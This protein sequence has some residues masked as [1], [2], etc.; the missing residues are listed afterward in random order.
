MYIELRIHQ[1]QKKLSNS[2]SN[3]FSHL[4]AAIVCM[5]GG[6]KGGGEGGTHGHEERVTDL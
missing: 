2:I 5:Q 3:G 4:A 6:R 1:A